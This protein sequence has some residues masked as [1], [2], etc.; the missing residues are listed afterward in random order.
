[1]QLFGLKNCDQCRAAM[2]DLQALGREVE[3]VDVRTDGVPQELLTAAHGEFQDALI[4]RRST[5]WRGLSDAERSSDLL[6]LLQQ[7]PTLM[8]RPLIVDGATMSL[9]WDAKAQAVWR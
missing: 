7:N 1:M 5:T 9:G 6:E 3:L 8:K 2:R 4:N